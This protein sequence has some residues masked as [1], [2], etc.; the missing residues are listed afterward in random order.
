[1]EGRLSWLFLP[2]PGEG[3]S[4]VDVALRLL[5]AW[6]AA[7]ALGWVYAGSHGVLSYKPTFVRSIVLL[8][9]VVCM[10]VNVVGDSIA[11]AFGMMAALAI[12]RFRT[13]IREP[14]DA[15]FLFGAVALGMTAGLGMTGVTV[16]ATVVLGLVSTYLHRTAYGT[17][18][19]DEGSLVFRFAG[20]APEDEAV[21]AVLSRNCS[22]WHLVKAT[23]AGKKGAPAG[24]D[25]VYQ[26]TLHDPRRADS[27]VR[28][29]TA[30][31]PVTEARILVRAYAGEA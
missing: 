8:S 16:V 13:A 9:L 11:Q 1:M 30:S 21:Q 25:R 12:V 23:P 2:I 22:R 20:G 7:M 31:A 27:L 10:I 24:E 18:S 5:I 15:L 17:R 29:L 14:R 28:E 3:V 26:V 19:G 6:L 4:L